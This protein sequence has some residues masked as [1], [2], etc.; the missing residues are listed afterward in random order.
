MAERDILSI[1]RALARALRKLEQIDW[2]LADRVRALEA[3]VEELR[4]A[5][6]KQS[7]EGEPGF[8]TE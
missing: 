3:D 2:Q 1:L 4:A 6:G 8:R 5:V 7:S